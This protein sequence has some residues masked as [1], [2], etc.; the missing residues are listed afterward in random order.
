MSALYRVGSRVIGDTHGFQFGFDLAQARDLGL[1]VDL[2]R[3]DCTLLA[4]L[5]GQRL[6]FAQQPQQLLLFFAFAGQFLVALRH[7]GLPFE[8]LQVAAEFAQNVLDPHQILARVVQA[9]FRFAPAFLVLGHARGL[10]QEDPQLLG[11]GL[12]DA[13]NHA[14]PDNRVGAGTETGTEEDVLDVAAACRQVVDVV[15]G[16]AVAGQHPLHG[17]LAVLA[18]LPG[19]TAVAVVE[20]Q[21]DAGPAARFTRSRAVEDHVLHRFAAQL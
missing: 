15:A 9:V 14:L 1:E 21:F 19:G 17:D 12:D 6:V 11:L 10:F 13:G 4:L 5:L 18:P 2:G 3:F 8:L 20:H 16:G 7:F